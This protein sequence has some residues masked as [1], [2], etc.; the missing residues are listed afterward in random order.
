MM[1]LLEM[2]ERERVKKRLN[3]L[4]E[5]ISYHNHRYYL[6]DDPEIADAEYDGLF[7][8]LEDLEGRYPELVTPDSP[9][10]RVGA[11]PLARFAP[12]RHTLP[13]LSLENA[14]NDGELADFETRLRRFLNLEGGIAYYA[15]PKLDGLA[16]ELVYENGL[17]TLGST[18]G[19]GLVGENISA[20]LRTI[21]DIPR[22]LS[23]NAIAAPTARKEEGPQVA[24]PG[25][26]LPTRLDVRGEV[27]LTVAGF[28]E[29]N[30]RRAEAGEALF[31]NPRNAAAGSLRQLDPAIT[32]TR[33][34]EFFAYGVADPGG[35]EVADQQALLQRLSTLGFK[36]IPHGRLCPDLAMVIAH[37]QHL[38]A[39]RHTLPYEIDG[40]VAKVHDLALQQRLG[41][42][43]RTPR[44]AI[45]A[46]FPAVQASSRLLA[47][48]FQVGRTGAITPVAHLDPVNVGGVM[49]SRATLHNEDEIRRKDLRIG[50][51]VLVQRAGEV[52]PEVVKPV[53]E[54][55]DGSQREIALP[56]HCP[57]CGARLVRPEGE[58]ISRCPNRESC[59]AQ[60]LRALIHFTGKAGLDIEGLGKKV[61]EQLTA[62]ELV[63]DIPDIFRLRAEQLAGLPGWGERSA[64][65]AMA[66]I[67]NRKRVELSRL[68]AALG[69]RHVGENGAQLIAAH[70]QTLEAILRA[71]EDDFHHIGGVGEKTA[72][73]LID[74]FADPA[75]REILGQLQRLGLQILPPAPPEQN[76]P[77][78]GQIMLFTGSLS[79]VSRNEAKARVKEL[80][81]QV[82]TTLNR[83][84]TH[85]VCG[86]SPGS[87]L[88]KARELGIAILDEEQFRQLIA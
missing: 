9:S 39:L 28:Q 24:A 40:M 80:G 59:P 79:G 26:N 19:D 17:F 63:R 14:F 23:G 85:L 86:Q 56:D 84:V 11:A 87:K 25:L 78:S 69:I 48:S 65:N 73:A 68:L 74:Y 58:A 83:K 29:L 81:G 22:R 35:L 20:N 38:N 2:A 21:A 34:L 33:P 71:E 49:V 45:A 55:R 31:A 13:M 67:N 36:I 16:V 32:A 18:R 47:V 77:L 3:E 57:E 72:S 76:Q 1:P 43:S 53:V 64:A 6:L 54:K 51:T 7:R 70:F 44:W 10:R 50:D 42:K 27:C 5:L 8:E 60:R 12:V 41:A 15:E 75:N 66:A 46:K 82:A 37:F 30:R 61:M 4:R 88:N 52:I 62:A